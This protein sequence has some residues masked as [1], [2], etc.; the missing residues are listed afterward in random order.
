MRHDTAFPVAS[1]PRAWEG[2]IDEA[3]GA[4][5]RDAEPAV[6]AGEVGTVETRHERPKVFNFKLVCAYSKDRGQ[7][8]K[9]RRTY[10][11]PKLEPSVVTPLGEGKT[12]FW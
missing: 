2:V 4:L 3:R 9:P 6:L 5:G 1:A 12:S 8:H 11:F 10:S 7:G